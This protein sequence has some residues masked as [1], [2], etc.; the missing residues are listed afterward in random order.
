MAGLWIL[1]DAS[2]APEF[3][4]QRRSHDEVVEEH[5][6]LDGCARQMPPS[7]M[8]RPPCQRRTSRFPGFLLLLLFALYTPGLTHSGGGNLTS[9]RPINVVPDSAP[10]AL[11]TLHLCAL[12]I[13]SF[14]R[15][16]RLFRPSDI[17]TGSAIAIELGTLRKPR[18]RLITLLGFRCRS[19]HR[20]P[21]IDFLA[22]SLHASISALTPT[23][24]FPQP[25]QRTLKSYR[26]RGQC[27]ASSLRCIFSRCSDLALNPSRSWIYPAPSTSQSRDPMQYD[28][29]SLPSPAQ[30]ARIS[31]LLLLSLHLA[32]ANPSFLSTLSDIFT[33]DFPSTSSLDYGS[34]SSLP[35][36]LA[37]SPPLSP[38]RPCPRASICVSPR[39]VCTDLAIPTDRRLK[40]IDNAFS[41]INTANR[42]SR[43]TAG[44]FT[45]CRSLH[46]PAAELA[47]SAVSRD[48]SSA[49]CSLLLGSRAP[50]LSAG[51]A[52]DARATRHADF[53]PCIRCGMTLGSVVLS[54]VAAVGAAGASRG[55]ANDV[56]HDAVGSRSGSHHSPGNAVQSAQSE[57][58][59]FPTAN[60]IFYPL[61]LGLFN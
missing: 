30:L 13:H 54:A 44:R 9:L 43:S 36:I 41:E 46:L 27:S 45:L 8:A 40:S 42:E 15:V 25:L 23:V 16:S 61:S 29:G 6:R 55:V 14:F 3:Q 38:R 19:S 56:A 52:P 32:R 5:E 60:P 4:V 37:V 35:R 12:P 26:R 48:R 22:G 33:A 59:F 20:L 47:P 10:P 51:V 57:I 1:I 58:Y 21:I 50:S 28:P 34:R 7:L 2:V 31:L 39:L 53:G 24:S 49:A 18:R 11:G 17:P